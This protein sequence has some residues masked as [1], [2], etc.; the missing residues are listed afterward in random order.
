MNSSTT[1]QTE[2]GEEMAD[3]FGN[4]I[5]MYIAEHPDANYR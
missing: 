1:I 3:L 4:Y 2:A 5:S